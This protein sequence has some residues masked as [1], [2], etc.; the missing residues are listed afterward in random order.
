MESCWGAYINVKNKYFGK[1][2]YK[3]KTS[4]QQKIQYCKNDTKKLHR[5]VTHLTGTEPRNPLPDDDANNDKDLANSFADF[6][7]SKIENIHE[8]FVGI[9]AYNPEK[10]ST[11]KLCQFT[12]MTES[13]VK[14]IM[15][16]MKSKSCKI[17]PIPTHIFKQLFP[18]VIPI[19]TKIVNLSLSKGEFCQIRKT[20]VV[21]PLLKKEGLDP[22]KPN[23]RLVS[24]LTFM[25]KVIEKCMLHHSNI[26]VIHITYS[27][28]INQHTGKITP[29]RPVLSD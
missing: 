19:V 21:R 9:E 25:S 20:A 11:P 27:W 13:E 2:K 22:I 26:T 18:S 23:Y 1:L 29:V 28:T 15:M 6:F 10:S 5:L 8:M 14:T 4:I 24:N 12:P 7:Q 16:S 3:K 17:D